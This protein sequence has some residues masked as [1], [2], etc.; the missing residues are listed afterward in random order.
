M[1]SKILTWVL[2]ESQ[3]K[4]E[5]SLSVVFR[6]KE[7]SNPNWVLCGSQFYYRWPT[8]LY[9]FSPFSFSENY[10][11]RFSLSLS[12]FLSTITEGKTLSLRLPTPTV[13]H[14]TLSLPFFSYSL[15]SLLSTKPPHR[16]SLLHLPSKNHH[17]QVPKQ[18]IG[19][20]SFEVATV[21]SKTIH[22]HKSLTDSEISMLKT[23]ILKSEGV[24][25]LVSS[26][27]SHPLDLALAKKLDDLN[28]VAAITVS[29]KEVPAQ[30]TQGE[31]ESIWAEIDL[32]VAPVSAS[33]KGVKREKE[34]CA[35]LCST[36]GLCLLYQHQLK[37][38]SLSRKGLCSWVKRERQSFGFVFKAFLFS[39]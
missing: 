36:V 31:Q 26:N 18:T 5:N 2:C 16:S 39:I 6:F 1:K 29:N 11:R 27:V 35:D 21:I 3:D 13:H 8:N 22:F 10:S 28:R 20:L 19:I 12:L 7:H 34:G 14:W 24:L 30:S 33:A 23:K 15:S 17:N 4:F 37:G 25:N 32:G 38:W 9:T